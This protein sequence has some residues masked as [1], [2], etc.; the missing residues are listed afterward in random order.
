MNSLLLRLLRTFS[1]LYSSGK[2]FEQEA[3]NMENMLDSTHPNQN[4]NNNNTST[5]QL[6]HVINTHEHILTQYKQTET[7]INNKNKTPHHSHQPPQAHYSNNQHPPNTSQN[8]PLTNTQITQQIQTLKQKYHCIACASTSQHTR[9]CKWTTF[10]CTKC[11]KK[12][13]IARACC[14]HPNP[15]LQP[16]NQNTLPPSNN[17]NPTNHNNQPPTSYYSQQPQF[18]PQLTPTIISNQ[19]Q[20]THHT[21]NPHSLNNNERM[22][23]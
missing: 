4:T 1:I 2:E 19:Q 15:L 13:H 16:T 5:T 6:Q 12:G 3:T 14:T 17:S 9:P 7:R 18:I 11:N 20:H 22:N 8:Q 21:S 23:K 10:T